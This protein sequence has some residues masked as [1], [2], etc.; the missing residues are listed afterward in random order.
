M[1]RSADGKASAY[2]SGFPAA[3][4]RDARLRRTLR[5]RAEFAAVASKGTGA[6]EP[7]PEETAKRSSRRTRRALRCHR[8][9]YEIALGLKG[10]T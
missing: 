10:T 4:L 9:S 8:A 6:A 1:M 7:H 3:I 2:G 5:M